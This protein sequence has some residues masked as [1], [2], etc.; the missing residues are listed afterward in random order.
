MVSKLLLHD[1]PSKFSVYLASTFFNPGLS[2]VIEPSQTHIVLLVSSM[3]GNPPILSFLATGPQGMIGTGIQEEGTNTGTG[4]AIFQFM[5]LAGDLHCPKA[6]MFRKGTKSIWVAIGLAVAF[7]VMPIG[8]TTI[9]L[10]PAPK[11][12]FSL[13]P[14]QTHFGINLFFQ[15]C[16]MIANIAQIPFFSQ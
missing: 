7:I 8:N 15:S 2:T 1:V 6:G 16:E 4:P 10:G 13:A 3:A 11:E 14:M 12:H 9:S 5:G